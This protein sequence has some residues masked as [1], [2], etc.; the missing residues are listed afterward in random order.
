MSVPTIFT[1]QSNGSQ[2]TLGQD[3]KALTITQTGLTSFVEQSN[4]QIYLGAQDHNRLGYPSIM[5]FTGA[6]A[7][8][9]IYNTGLTIANRNKIESYL[10]IKYGITLNQTTPTNYTASGGA[11]L[12]NAAAGSGYINNIAGIARDDGF[13]LSQKKSQSTSNTGDIIVEYT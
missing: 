7:E 10:A 3:G 4:R 11:I 5:Y 8:L 2:W 12:W 9:I 1:S 13:S 6:I